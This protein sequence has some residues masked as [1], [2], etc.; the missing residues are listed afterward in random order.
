M[1]VGALIDA[2]AD[3]AAVRDGIE[4]LGVNGFH[5]AAEKVTK[6]GLSATQF[7]VVQSD[8]HQPHR[9]LHHIVELIENA[10]L[11]APV[12]TASIAT[13]Q[14]IAECE[15]QV[16]G[17]TPNH[18]HFHEVGAIDSIAD[19]VGA[20]LA[21]HLLGVDHIR[22]SP[23]PL[24]SGTIS[25]A[26]GVLPVPAPATALLVKGAPCYGGDVQGELLTPTGAALITQLA[27]AFGPMPMMN[28]SAIG[29]G[30]GTREFPDRPNVLRVFIGEETVESK[31]HETV[32]IIETNLDDMNPEFF[33]PLIA[34]MLANGARDAFLTPILGK[35]GRPGYL[36]TVLTDDAKVGNLTELLLRETTTLGVRIRHEQRTCLARDW[37]SVNTPWGPVRVKLGLRNG[38]LVKAVPEFEDCRQLAEKAACPLIAVYQAAQAAAVRGEFQHD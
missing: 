7:H 19:I 11:P 6:S 3:I 15:A 31:C 13:F 1:I 14:R 27:S 35:K 10:G 26:H 22:S 25:C 37:R 16:H 38:Q 29:C 12:K 33:P 24:G 9:H 4:S 2:G 21:L 18:V 36:I 5:V 30:S 28:I 32:S 23:L 20:H 8:E 17:T 34:A